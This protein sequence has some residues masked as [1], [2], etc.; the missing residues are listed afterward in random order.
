[1]HI[2]ALLMMLI[3]FFHVWGVDGFKCEAD[4]HGDLVFNL[5]VQEGLLLLF[6]FDFFI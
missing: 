4:V 5:S 3:L 2:S 6:L 1:M